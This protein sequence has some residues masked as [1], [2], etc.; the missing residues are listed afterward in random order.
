MS[1]RTA[2]R[3]T[4]V[5]FKKRKPRPWPELLGLPPDTPR[6]M[7]DY[8]IVDENGR[9]VWAKDLADRYRSELE[10]RQRHDYTIKKPPTPGKP[11]KRG[12][13][14]LGRIWEGR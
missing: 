13:N 14:A 3:R 2:S 1:Q 6:I 7:W 8:R 12:G 10:R 9:T 4:P 11:R 5:R